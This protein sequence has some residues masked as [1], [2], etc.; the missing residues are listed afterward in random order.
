MKYNESKDTVRLGQVDYWSLRIIPAVSL[1]L[2][3]LLFM[4][5]VL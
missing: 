5:L 1:T 4:T 2:Y 3:L